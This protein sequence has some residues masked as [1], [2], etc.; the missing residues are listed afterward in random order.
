MDELYH[1]LGASHKYPTIYIISYIDN[2]EVKRIMIDE[3]S[4][5]N[6]ISTIALQHLNIPLLYLSALTL[7][8]RSINNTFSTTLGVVLPVMVGARSIT[9]AYHVV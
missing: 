9:I 1:S 3:G 7:I 4:M 5:I 6:V 8:I 2:K